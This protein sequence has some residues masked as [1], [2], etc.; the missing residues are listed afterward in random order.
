MTGDTIETTLDWQ[1]RGIHARKLAASDV[2]I[3]L[4]PARL[5]SGRGTDREL[6][7]EAWSFG[8]MIENAWMRLGIDFHR[9]PEMQAQT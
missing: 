1:Q 3:S 4:L 7:I 9:L 2:N 5:L 8:W 6:S